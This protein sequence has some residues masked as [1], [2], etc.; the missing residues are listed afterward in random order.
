[1]FR[2]Y[3][4]FCNYIHI[5]DISTK[6]QKRPWFLWLLYFGPVSKHNSLLIMLTNSKYFYEKSILICCFA[7]TCSRGAQKLW[8][9]LKFCCKQK[10]HEN[11]SHVTP[12]WKKKTTLLHTQPITCNFKSIKGQSCSE[13]LREQAVHS[14][15]VCRKHTN[16]FR[17]MC[18]FVPANPPFF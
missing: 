17:E 12:A 14:R 11:T 5:S 18:H 1:M 7:S 15:P 6:T 2:N 3:L 10:L 13:K 16:L 4:H 8:F 9:N